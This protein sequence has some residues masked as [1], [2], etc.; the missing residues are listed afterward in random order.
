MVAPAEPLLATL[1]LRTCVSMSVANQRVFC[2]LAIYIS[3]EH[4]Q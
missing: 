4:T 3:S 2:L 1:S